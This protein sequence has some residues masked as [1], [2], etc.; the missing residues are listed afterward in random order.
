M[1]KRTGT[2][3]RSDD[4]TTNLSRLILIIGAV[5]CESVFVCGC[6]V[7]AKMCGGEANQGILGVGN[8]PDN[9]I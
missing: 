9:I 5:I 8:R 3:Q 1:L 7:V 6:D 4:R 2:K